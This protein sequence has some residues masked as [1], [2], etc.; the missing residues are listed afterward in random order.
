MRAGQ[1]GGN[2]DLRQA[3]YD[4]CGADEAGGAAELPAPDA[5]GAAPGGAADEGASVGPNV[6]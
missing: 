1:S 5:A 6:H 2:A 4:G 3:G